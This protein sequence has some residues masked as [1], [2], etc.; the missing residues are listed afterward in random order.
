[1]AIAPTGEGLAFGDADGYVHLW[2]AQEDA[3]F[4]R[5][6]GEVELPDTVEAPER[7]DWR[8][9]RCVPSPSLPYSPLIPRSPLNS[10]GM[11]Y[12]TSPLL[13]LLPTSFDFTPSPLHHTRVPLDPNIL[14]TVKTVDFVG[15]APYPASARAAGRRNQVTPGPGGKGGKRRVDVPMFRSEKER[16][17]TKKKRD[18][19]VSV[20]ASLALGGGEELTGDFGAQ[21]AKL[22]EEEDAA[23]AQMPNHYRKVEIKY[24]RFG[25]EDFDFGCIPPARTLRPS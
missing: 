13:S 9:D 19:V 23:S 3:K 15:Y 24:S 4:C 11:P 6:E 14:A 8:D 7:I 1:M 16:A 20:R 10:I 2:A 17:E 21:V 5:F 25:V 12:Y 22:E 18:R